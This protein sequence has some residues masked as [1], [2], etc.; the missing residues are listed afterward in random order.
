MEITNAT[1]DT[2]NLRGWSLRYGGGNRYRFDN[3]RATIRFQTHRPQHP[4]R[5][6]PGP[7]WLHVGQ[8]LWHCDAV[9]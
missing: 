4:L 3:G 5:P 8:P 7:L 2:V 6:V 9:R 1:R